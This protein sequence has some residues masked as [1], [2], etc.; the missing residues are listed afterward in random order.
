MI[1]IHLIPDNPG[2]NVAWNM[3]LQG[4]SQL[5]LQKIK[6]ISPCFFFKYM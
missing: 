1:V 6:T 2:K 3:I 4:Y 5:F